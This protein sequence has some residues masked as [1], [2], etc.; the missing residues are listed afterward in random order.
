LLI[1]DTFYQAVR[2]RANFISTIAKSLASIVNS[3]DSDL[4]R[5]KLAELLEFYMSNYEKDL[6]IF[7]TP[8]DPDLRSV[9]KCL[10]WAT[11]QD[12]LFNANAARKLSPI[13]P[14]SPI[15]LNS[16]ILDDDISIHCTDDFFEELDEGSDYYYYN[17]DCEDDDFASS[18]LQDETCLQSLQNDDMM[19]NPPCY[20]NDLE[21]PE[22]KCTEQIFVDLEEIMSEGSEQIVGAEHSRDDWSF[23][24][25]DPGSANLA[26][27][28]REEPMENM[29]SSFDTPNQYS[30][31]PLLNN[32]FCV[33]VAPLEYLEP[34]PF[35]ENINIWEPS[36][37]NMTIALSTPH[38]DDDEEMLNE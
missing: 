27:V 5:Q 30:S 9:F 28:R 33:E 18:P 21:S 37:T 29:S 16:P 17:T 11:A 22:Q 26:T 36:N 12:G 3:T 38:H 4:L 19:I 14:T 15:E 20:S 7:E 35:E 31:S 13:Y 6:E 1:A 24:D 23:S 2:Q 34:T 10:L 8:E 32:E 25:I